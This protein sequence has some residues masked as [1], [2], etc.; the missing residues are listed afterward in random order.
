MS[1]VGFPIALARLGLALRVRH[2]IHRKS[3][4]PGEWT[5]DQLM[6]L[7]ARSMKAEIFAVP[8]GYQELKDER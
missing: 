1:V 2:R 7:E 5:V 8:A 6:L 4:S 3:E